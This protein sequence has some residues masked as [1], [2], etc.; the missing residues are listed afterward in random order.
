MKLRTPVHLMLF[1]SI[2]FVTLSPTAF[3]QGPSPA[4]VLGTPVQRPNPKGPNPVHED[5]K[6]AILAAFDHY[7][8]VGINTAHGNQNLDSFILDLFRDPAFPGKIND[9]VVECGNSL[10]Q[11][12]LDRYIAGKE[13]TLAEV[14]QVWRNTTQPMC[15][16]SAF[17][18][19][20]FPLV[21]RLNQRLSP[22]GRVRV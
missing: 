17:Y 4:T 20:L 11:P 18:E 14:R 8:V 5:A 7:E 12:V 16:V 6:K 13:V 22:E 3:A 10:Y 21:R 2:L 1:C 9:V 19:E 15:G